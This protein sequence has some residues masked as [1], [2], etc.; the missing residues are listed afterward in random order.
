MPVAT[1]IEEIIPRKGDIWKDVDPRRERFIRVEGLFAINIAMRAV[2][3]EGGKW[4]DAPKSR[5]DYAARKRFNGKSG[6]YTLHF[7]EQTP[8]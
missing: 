1:N 7:R 5:K 3:L 4:I 6:G 8:I 2:V